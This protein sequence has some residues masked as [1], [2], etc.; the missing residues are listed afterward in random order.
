[1]FYSIPHV[2]ICCQSLLIL[3]HSNKQKA[4]QCETWGEGDGCKSETH[5]LII[6]SLSP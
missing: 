2:N 3:S 1:M 5:V 4:S 6:G